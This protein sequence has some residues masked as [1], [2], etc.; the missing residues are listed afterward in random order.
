MQEEVDALVVQPLQDA[1][2]IRQ[3]STQP[4][5]RPCRDHVEFLGVHRL[6]H[7]IEPRT[8]VPALGTGY[9]GILKDLDDLPAGSCG[10]SLQFTTLVA[11]LLFRG[12]NPEIDGNALRG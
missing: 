1:E 12:A 11:G 2:E 9:P 8:L 5:N 10:D 7:R 3:R 6:H 4:I